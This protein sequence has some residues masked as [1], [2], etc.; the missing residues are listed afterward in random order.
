MEPNQV[1]TEKVNEQVL[2]AL[3]S[4]VRQLFTEYP[5]AIVSVQRELGVSRYRAQ[6]V[7]KKAG[8]KPVKKGCEIAGKLR[9]DLERGKPFCRILGEVNVGLKYLERIARKKDIIL[10][11]EENH[12]PLSRIERKRI[13]HR[14]E[15]EHPDSAKFIL[16]GLT[17]E[18]IGKR[19]RIVKKINGKET[20]K[21]VTREHV[22]QY[23]EIMGA[24][25][26]R[27]N[28]HHHYRI[29]KMDEREKV[30]NDLKNV[31]RQRVNKVHEEI[32]STWAEKKAR[33][34]VLNRRNWESQDAPNTPYEKILKLF[35]YYEYGK[36]TGTQ[37]TFK[38][39]G[40]LSGLSGGAHA[41]IILSSLGLPSLCLSRDTH[42][43]RLS[44][45]EKNKL[46][47][48]FKDISGQD[49]A[50]FTGRSQNVVRLHEGDKP[51]LTRYAFYSQVYYGI[52]S[53][54]SLEDIALCLDKTV[55]LIQKALDRRSTKEPEIINILREL[56]PDKNITTPYLTVYRFGKTF[57][58]DTLMRERIVP[59][60]R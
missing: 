14:L 17:F 24:T 60:S 25:D 33:V 11:E 1:V 13:R 52:D 50:H 26:Y 51:I 36:T 23:V 44:E 28:S 6:C 49:M 42:F 9:Y 40:E 56:Y 47:N 29:S 27:E 19:H 18:E 30:R 55:P 7:I 41:G 54:L 53:G 16:R 3:E 48:I 4:R 38:E 22:R 10:P 8:F 20:L 58:P 43:E 5:R 59:I 32:P 15:E 37:L 46:N 12:M 2:E 45:E 57:T 39:L 35:Q 31:L 21:S 34:Y